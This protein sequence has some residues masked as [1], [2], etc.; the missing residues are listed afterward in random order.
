MRADT[1]RD[2]TVLTMVEKRK[3]MRDLG[4]LMADRNLAAKWRNRRN[5]EVAARTMAAAEGKHAVVIATCGQGQVSNPSGLA[6]TNVRFG[7][8]CSTKVEKKLR[9][10]ARWSGAGDLG[11]SLAE[12][13]CDAKRD[14]IGPS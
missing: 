7:L 6:P 9:Q 4:Y 13:C 1:T 14:C 8:I 3:G 2:A 11:R 5:G 10:H 12:R